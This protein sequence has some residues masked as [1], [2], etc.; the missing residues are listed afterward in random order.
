MF[1]D[2]PIAVPVVELEPAVLADIPT[3]A[4]DFSV[5]S[6]VILSALNFNLKSHL[7]ADGDF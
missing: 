2:T 7:R 6:A 1:L 4:V 3:P 5:P